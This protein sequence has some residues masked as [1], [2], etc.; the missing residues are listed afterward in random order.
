MTE[1]EEEPP[2]SGI[3]R[4][5]TAEEIAEATLLA[6]RIYDLA[7]TGSRDPAMALGA[8]L[9]AYDNLCQACGLDSADCLEAAVRDLR[10]CNE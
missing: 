5:A 4:I 6:E 2:P 1:A 9:V 3:E 8:V 7:R 10:K